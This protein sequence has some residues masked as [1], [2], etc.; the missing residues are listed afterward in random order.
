VVSKTRYLCGKYTKAMSTKKNYKVQAS[1]DNLLLGVT[2]FIPDAS[3][4]V[5]GVLQMVHGMA[6]H[7]G[8]YE[9]LMEY[10]ADNGYICVI[11]SV[12]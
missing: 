8:R 9:P 12:H 1:A 10:L 6:E 3:D 7:R 11:I 2:A 5:K 4:P